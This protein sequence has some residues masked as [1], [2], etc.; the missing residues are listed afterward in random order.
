MSGFNQN[1][2]VGQM[3]PSNQAYFYRT[4]LHKK[5]FSTGPDGSAGGKGPHLF[6]FSFFSF[7]R[8]PL[9]DWLEQIML[10]SHWSTQTGC[11]KH[12]RVPATNKTVLCTLITVCTGEVAI[13][14]SF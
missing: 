5:S 1:Q 3:D 8:G 9:L 7:F 6:S 14:I 13:G 11:S 12:A 2:A 10:F 4:S